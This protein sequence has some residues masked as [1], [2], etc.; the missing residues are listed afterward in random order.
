M[1]TARSNA[2]REMAIDRIEE[3]SAKELTDLALTA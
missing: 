2:L 3:T 1:V